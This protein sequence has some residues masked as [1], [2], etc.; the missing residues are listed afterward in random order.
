[1]VKI[2]ESKKFGDVLTFL[3][4]VMVLVVINQVSFRHF[5]RIDL[6]DEQRYSIKPATQALL[7]DLDDNVYVEVYLEGDL[8]P[9]L[10]RL[11]KAVRET[12]QEFEVYSDHKVQFTF[13]DPG[14][15]MSQG[16]RNE[17]MADLNARGL[18]PVNI[19]DTEDGQR[20]EKIVFPGALVSYGGAEK[21]V[22]LL[23]GTRGEEQLNNSIEGVEYALA[24]TIYK[25]SALGRKKVGFLQGHGELNGNEI[26]SLQN[27][28]YEF[29]ELAEINLSREPVI[30]E[31]LDL[32]VLARPQNHFSET[33]KYKIDQYIMKGGKAIFLVDKLHANM[34][35]ASNETNF[36]LPYDMDLDDMLFRYGI[37][38]N[39]DLV[40]DNNAAPYPIVTGMVGDRPQIT[41]IPWPYY[42]VLNRFSEHTI[43]RDLG[44]V[45]GRFVS[46]MDT[47]KAEGIRKTPLI[48]T[49]AYSRSVTAP[50]NISVNDLRKNVKPEDLNKSFLPVAYLLEGKFRS[51]FKNRFLPE[52]ADK[53]SFVPDGEEAKIL[54]ISDG[55][56]VRND[57]NPRTG[58]PE[59]LGV[60][61]FQQGMKFSNADFIQNAVAFLTEENGIITARNKEIAIRP[62]DKVEMASGKTKWQMINIVLPIALVLLPGGLY[63]IYRKYRYSKFPTSHE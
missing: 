58:A 50:V 37:R 18:Q 7:N 5:T 24:S 28:L 42:P 49:S 46:T 1:M 10:Q 17:F 27:A 4:G 20:T 29:Y 33:D 14:L 2:L 12:L 57:I 34:D 15:A 63:F 35:S 47:V 8:N 25:L 30:P 56:F 52:G 26:I 23:M 31:D 51:V 48:F 11:Q 22:M 9:A 39:N 54:V 6:T 38:L 61:P 59:E 3:A 62:L 53:N 43:S 55:D 60:Y 32:V 21:A 36:A 16:A 41:P 13:V 40:Q 44:A 45:I 19:I